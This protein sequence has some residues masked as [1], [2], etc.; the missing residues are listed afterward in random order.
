MGC[1]KVTRTKRTKMTG[2]LLMPK[3]SCAALGTTMK[4]SYVELEIFIMHL[5][6]S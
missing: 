4:T 2:S 5:I 1:G 3:Q 6:V